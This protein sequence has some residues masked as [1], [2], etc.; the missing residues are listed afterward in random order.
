M[1]RGEWFL[2]LA[3]FATA[4]LLLRLA[5]RQ[6][7]LA[8]WARPISLPD[9]GMIAVSLTLL[10]FHCAAMFAPETVSR[11]PFLD[12]P[13]AVVRDL[14]DPLGQAAYW[15]PAVALVIGTRRSWW[16]A[17]AGLAVGLLAVGWT[18]YGDFTVTQHVVTIVVTSGL[19]AVVLT[20]LVGRSNR[21]VAGS[22]G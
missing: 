15:I 20:G 19:I 18:M 5:L 2:G 16:P 9:A 13:A 8:R 12:G 7:L 22:T 6:P 4:L 17:T 11:F 3:V 10:V 1:M 21:H 14:R